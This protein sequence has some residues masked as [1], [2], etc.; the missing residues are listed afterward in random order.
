MTFGGKHKRSFEEYHAVPDGWD[1][2][3]LASA[4]ATLHGKFDIRPTQIPDTWDPW[5]KYRQTLYNVANGVRSNDVACVELAVRFIEFHF[6]GSYAGFIRSRKARRLK[7]SPLTDKQQE[8][9]SDHFLGP[10][11]QGER[12]HEFSDY[13]SLW[14]S[15][16][17]PG[18]LAQ[19]EQLARDNT[20]QHAEFLVYV[21]TKLRPN[22]AG[23]WSLGDH[24]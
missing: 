11:R 14:R 23:A 9:L 21:L 7:H 2:A 10:L 4:H 17:T 1:A 8:R 6:I 20:R 24:A 13:L 19:V 18:D 5:L 15:I 22:T 3:S 16:A 12:C